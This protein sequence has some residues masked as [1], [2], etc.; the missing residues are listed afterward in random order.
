MF[1]NE[2]YLDYAQ[3]LSGKRLPLAFVDLAAFDA[4]IN[5]VRSIVAG[6]G[7]T[8]RVGTKSIRCE[9]L[10]KRIFELGGQSFQGLLTYTAEETA[11]LAE[12]GYD[13]FIIAYPTVQK[14]DLTLILPLEHAF[15]PYTLA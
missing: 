11:W 12:K 13:D 7:R 9:A 6:T 10:T 14:S 5:Y 15:K 8:I 3:T 1:T 4:N 2:L